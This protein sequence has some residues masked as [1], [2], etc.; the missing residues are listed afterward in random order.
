[1]AGGNQLS[2]ESFMRLFDAEREQL[3]RTV[4]R[5]VGCQWTAEDIVQDTLVRLWGRPLA[6]K[7]RG[8]LYTTARNLAIDHMRAR[9]VREDYVHRSANAE[10][11]NDVDRPEEKTIFDEEFSGLVEALSSLPERAQRVF[12]LNRLDGLPYRKIAKQLR[13]SVST[14][15]KDMIQAL[16]VCRQW[17]RNLS[18]AE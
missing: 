1:M 18:D 13:V 14:V 9:R 12:L 16:T 4:K 15:E 7:N 11:F 10:D 6:E 8:L 3:V 5:V 2:N 17:Q